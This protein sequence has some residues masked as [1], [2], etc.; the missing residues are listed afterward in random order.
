[1]YLKNSICKFNPLFEIDYSKKKNIISASFF[2]IQGGGYT[3]FEKYLNGI[4]LL[5]EFI[6]KELPDFELRLFIDQTISDDIFIFEKLKRNKIKLITFECS[7]FL[8]DKFHRGIFGMIVRFFPMFNFE[9]ND[10][11]NIIISDIDISNEIKKY[12]ITL[13]NKI[14]FFEKNNIK[15]LHSYFYGTLRDI[16]IIRKDKIIPFMLSSLQ[17]NFQRI[18]SNVLIQYINNYKKYNTKILKTYEHATNKIKKSNDKYIFYGW[19]EYFINNNYINH[20]ISNEIPFSI[21]YSYFITINLFY[22]Q[23]KLHVLENFHYKILE[24]FYRSILRDTKKFTFK[25]INQSF[26]YIDNLFFNTDYTNLNNEQINISFK[27]YEFYI[28]NYHDNLD[29]FGKDFINVILSDYYIGK[30]EFNED[31]YYNSESKLIDVYFNKLPDELITKLKD[32]K[33]KNNIPKVLI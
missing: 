21:T 9:N 33:I 30:I 8:I 16:S 24:K 14:N 18:D 17:I 25:N 7:N 15:D 29:L 19:D 22:V 27:I 28:E 12:L 1:M 23:K 13:R 32:L 20:L 10:A 11:K 5:N 2:K 3:S 31:K 26:N 6:I 4:F